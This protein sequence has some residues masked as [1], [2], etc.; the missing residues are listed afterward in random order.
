MYSR[1][2]R[3]RFGYKFAVRADPCRGSG[4]SSMPAHIVP[5]KRP[6]TRPSPRWRLPP[7]PT[8][9]E[10]KRNWKELLLEGLHSGEPV[11]ADE[12][13]WNR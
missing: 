12:S 11:E 10:P 1:R 2:L 8:S 6:L 13:F 3:F 9:R 4:P 7:F 5:L